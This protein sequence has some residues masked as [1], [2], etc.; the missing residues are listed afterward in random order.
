LPFVYHEFAK[1][2][3]AFKS[4]HAKSKKEMPGESCSAG[5]NPN[6]HLN[7]FSVFFFLFRVSSAKQQNTKPATLSR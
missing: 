2:F 3:G 6:L 5:Y 7:R 1:K 4:P